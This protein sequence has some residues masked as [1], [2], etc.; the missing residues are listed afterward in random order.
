MAEAAA[1]S[2][3]CGFESRPRH[4][5]F[6]ELA[7]FGQSAGV[8]YQRFTGS[9]PVLG[10]CQVINIYYVRINMVTWFVFLFMGIVALSGIAIWVSP[11]FLLG[12]PV[13]LYSWVKYGYSRRYL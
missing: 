10:T 2:G 5:S 12:I 7:Q 3:R 4:V 13:F 1:R 9:T 11:F 6:A 8:K